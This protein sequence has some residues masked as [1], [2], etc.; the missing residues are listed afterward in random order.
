MW[1][2]LCL[3]LLITSGTSSERFFASDG[4][5]QVLLD[6]VWD[7]IKFENIN[8]IGQVYKYLHKVLFFFFQS[9]WKW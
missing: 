3:F 5:R 8:D 7:D 9:F 4:V 2:S 1:M 6:S